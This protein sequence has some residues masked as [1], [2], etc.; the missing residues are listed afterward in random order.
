MYYIININKTH[1][2]NTNNIKDYFYYI[3]THTYL[4][5]IN[6][7]FNEYRYNITGMLHKCSCT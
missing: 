2:K 7:I 1:L 4:I 3:Y 5:L 6:D